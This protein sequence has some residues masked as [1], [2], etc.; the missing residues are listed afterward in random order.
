MAG[1]R[2]YDAGGWD[3]DVQV[4]G[5]E[6]GTRGVIVIGRRSIRELLR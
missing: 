6:L 3:V 4:F 5:D 2:F 1:K